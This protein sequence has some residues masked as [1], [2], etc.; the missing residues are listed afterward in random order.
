[1]R[2]MEKEIET[3]ALTTRLIKSDWFVHFLWLQHNSGN[4]VFRC[5]TYVRAKAKNV[6]AYGKDCNKPK[7]G[8][9]LKHEISA[10]HKQSALVP[11]QQLAFTTA[12]VTTIDHAIIVGIRQYNL[13][14]LVYGNEDE[15]IDWF[16]YP[17]LHHA[18]EFHTRVSG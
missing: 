18:A 17:W 1:M 14:S 11:K 16:N 2:M 8:D 4:H 13:E 10:D 15:P 9:L 6:F 12:R 5:T 3:P 7:K